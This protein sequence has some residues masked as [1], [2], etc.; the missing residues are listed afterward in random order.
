MNREPRE[1]RENGLIGTRISARPGFQND[2]IA[3]KKNFRAFRAF[4]GSE[5]FFT[6]LIRKENDST[7]NH[8]NNTKENQ[9]ED[10]FGGSK[11]K[12]EVSFVDGNALVACFD[13]KINVEQ[14]FKQMSPRT[15][16]RSI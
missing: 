14:I 6:C 9:G 1:L 2:S 4:R 5:S 16:V 12:F 8:T 3:V 13:N 11:S 15:E 10:N 7:A